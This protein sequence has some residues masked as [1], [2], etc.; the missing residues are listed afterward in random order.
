LKLDFELLYSGAA[1]LYV[2]QISIPKVG[3]ENILYPNL[4]AYSSGNYAPLGVYPANAD[5]AAVYSRL[6]PLSVGTNIYYGLVFGAYEADGAEHLLGDLGTVT[7]FGSLS[8]YTDSSTQLVYSGPFESLDATGWSYSY[9]SMTAPSTATLTSPDG[10]SYITQVSANGSSTTYERDPN[11]NQIQFGTSAYT[12]TIGRVIPYPPLPGATGNANTSNCT[13]PLPIVGASTWNPP[14]QGTSSLSYTFCFAS[15]PVEYPAISNISG[16]GQV[17]FMT[18]LQS[19]ILPNGT[20]WTFQ[21]EDYNPISDPAGTNYGN[22]TSITLPT[23]GTIAYTYS[24][25][26]SDGTMSVTY[27]RCVSTRTVNANDGTGP[28]TWTYNRSYANG[29]CGYPNTCFLQVQVLDPVGNSTIH[30]FQLGTDSEGHYETSAQYYDSANNLLKT[31]STAYSSTFGVNTTALMNVVPTSI[32]TTMGNGNT[33]S[34][35]YSYDPGFSI[36]STWGLTAAS[37]IHYGKKVA[38]YE[39]GYGSGA[40]G[41]LIRSTTTQYRWQQASAYL[42]AN[43]LNTPA[44]VT[45]L[46]GSGSQVAQTTYGY[47]ESNG[48]PQGVLGNVTSVTR[49]LNTGAAQP[50]TQTIYNSEGMPVKTLDA[51]LNPVT[52]SYDSTGAFLIQATNALGQNTTYQ[53]DDNSG[54]LSL[55]K[56]VNGQPTYYSYD[57]VSRTLMITYADS[58]QKAYCYSDNPNTACSASAPPYSAVLTQTIGNGA[59]SEVQ[60]GKVDG[61]GRPVQTQLNSDPDGTDYTDTAYDGQGRVYS[62]SSPHRASPSLTDG[63]TFYTYDGLNRKTIQ[64]NQDGTVKQWCYDGIA[65]TGQG[66]CRGHIAGGTGEWV[67]VADENG[68]DWQYTYDALN[69]LTSVIESSGSGPS[70][71]METD[72]GYDALGNLLSVTQWG[73]ISGTQGA[74]LRSFTYDS[75]SRL[76]TAANPE[77]GTICYGTWSGSSCVNGYDANGNLLHKTD[78]RGVVVNFTYD[79]LNRIT[80]KTYSNDASKTPLACYQYDSSPLASANAIGRLTNQWTQPV[81]AGACSNALPSNGYL[82]RRSILAYDPMG[83]VLSEQQCTPSNC[84]SGTSYSPAYTYYLNGHVYTSTNGISSTPIVNTLTFTSV[85]SPAARLQALSSNW[86]DATHPATLLSTTVSPSYFP[87]GELENATFGGALTLQRWYDNRL[88]ITG[89]TDTGNATTSSTSGAAAVAISGLEQFK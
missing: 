73:G 71:S 32:T 2:M 47:D 68:N 40:P 84:S 43:L 21:Y 87:P 70:P 59:S 79:A 33:S 42:T 46:N 28:H 80:G 27:K 23:G 75:L 55:E 86:I 56:D 15:V 39:Y 20:S 37:G 82:T 41:S 62:I 65:T 53:F 64:T 60:T 72:Y 81:S 9:T 36:T 18:M 11:N 29:P 14:G 30:N 54:L 58:G 85:L 52:Y 3:T 88:R 63:T 19:V 50:K 34:V 67:D 78:A 51:N 1:P 49:W 31:V 24:N 4:A 8:G 66:N 17:V 45:V 5:S 74:R 12:D 69:R 48:S 26:P 6:N 61:F 83:R 76:L 7:G 57:L 77:T 35:V 22:L 25:C 10:S 89:E 38:S 16:S 44:L 13:G